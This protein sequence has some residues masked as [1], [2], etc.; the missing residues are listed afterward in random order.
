MSFDSNRLSHAYISNDSFADTLAMAVVCSARD[1]NRPCMT[2]KHC[3]KASRQV[4]PD[5]ITVKQNDNKLI[6]S[7]DQI[8]E[9]KQDVYIV[10]NDAEKKAY[11]VKD[12]DT[13][14]I[15]AQNAFLRILEEPPAHAVFIL[16]TDNPA[17]LLPTVRSRCIEL[18]SLSAGEYT[19]DISNREEL[20]DIVCD[21]AEALE[22][23]NVKLMECM[24]RIDKLDRFALYDFLA[25]AGKKVVSMLRE[26]T[27][28]GSADT[29]KNLVHAES[30]LLKAGEMLDLNVSAGHIS[31]FICANLIQIKDQK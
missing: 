2:C 10:P 20:E 14:N 11:V 6:I 21:F 13:M 4:H 5:I 31:G 23:D 25:L 24:F 22:G 17:A 15:S 8:R 30:V 27:T 1:D 29:R 3:D 7:V 26:S 19:D 9:L 12:A 28:T 18:K 16:S